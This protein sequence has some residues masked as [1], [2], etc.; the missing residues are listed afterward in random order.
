MFDLT[1]SAFM[2]GAV[3]VL[4][5]AGPLVLGLWTGKLTDQRDRRRLLMVARAI[6]GGA[7]GLLAVLLLVRGVDGFGGPTVLL[8]GAG[9]MG[10]GHAL[11][12]PAMQALTPGLV[13]DADLEQAL[14]FASVAPSIARAVGP[15][16]GAGLLLLGG[17]GLA[18]A[19]AAATHWAFVLVLAWV[20]ARPRPGGSTGVSVLGGVRYLVHDRVAGLLLLGIAFLGF[21][22]DP[23]ITLT[24]SLASRLG[25][26][27]QFV[28]VL[29]TV[30]GVGAVVVVVLFR[31]LRQLLS[32]RAVGV[33][34][35]LVVVAGLVCTA[36]VPTVAGAVVGFLINGAGFMMATVALNTRIQR[37]VP[38][39]LRGRV[40]ALWAV[41]FLGSR[42]LAAP[43]NGAIADQV[44]VTAALLTA[45]TIVLTAS[46]LACARNG[47][48]RP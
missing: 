46:I 34:G 23:V 9:V 27:S 6:T 8:V 15:A 10:I 19:G 13:P 1:G 16:L 37:R 32:L 22:A 14:A 29:A 18:F 44:S 2:V 31:R 24:P 47:G 30:F 48:A 42:P 45:A 4:L 26:G 35:F 39:E 36:A 3:S 40:M 25:G 33:A 5:F 28:G 11:S 41:A 38:D 12:A 43:I 7:V 21:G 20:R 17:P